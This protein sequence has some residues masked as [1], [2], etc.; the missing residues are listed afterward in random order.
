MQSY[1]ENDRVL[2]STIVDE[3]Q[4]MNKTLE[5]MLSN[6]SASYVKIADF[7]EGETVELKGLQFKISSINQKA[8][9]LTLVMK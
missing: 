9:R 3:K 6:P 5:K 8:K 7:S 4:T 1:N 2:E